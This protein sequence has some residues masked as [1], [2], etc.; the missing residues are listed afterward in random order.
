MSYIIIWNPTSKDAHIHTDTYGFIEHF[1][2]RN[3]AL[4]EAE[5]CKDGSDFRTFMLFKEDIY[6]PI[7]IY[8]T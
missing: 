5:A 8:N 1:E 6:K 3:D 4:D 7:K 2:E